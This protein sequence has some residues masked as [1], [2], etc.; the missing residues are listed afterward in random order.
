MRFAEDGD[1]RLSASQMLIFWQD[2]VSSL[3]VT[4]GTIKGVRTA[5]GIEIECDAVVLTNGT[6]LKRVDPYR[7]KEIWWRRHR[8]NGSNRTYRTVG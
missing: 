7:R 5:L 2:M 6:F 1:W 8:R 3:L 4:N